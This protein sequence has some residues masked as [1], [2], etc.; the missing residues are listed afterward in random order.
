MLKF[1]RNKKNQ[2]RIYILLAIAIIPPFLFWG[3]MVSQE[4][5][6]MNPAT[7]LG[8][9][10]NHSISI[11]EYLKSYQAIQHQVALVYGEKAK[12][13]ARLIDFK[14]E[15]WDRLLLLDYAKKEKIKISDSEVVDYLQNQPIF[16]PN[17]R[18]DEQFYKAY[19]TNYLRI[20][21]RDFEEEIRQMLT[22][23]KIQD[24]MSPG[25][26]MLDKKTTEKM[27]ALLND[28]RKKLSVN[29]DLMNKLFTP[30]EQKNNQ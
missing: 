3:V 6:K 30:Q 21:T 26:K 13:I 11:Q 16:N 12:M 22:I 2:K 5:K 4:D 10:E 14:T 24:K 1:F 15:A 20:S 23:R 7:A 29:L 25:E 17:G 9:I 28:L 18:F 19:T 27:D 8:R